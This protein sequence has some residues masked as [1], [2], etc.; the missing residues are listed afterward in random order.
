MLK[1]CANCL[2]SAKP[3]RRER[4]V[5]SKQT[6]SSEFVYAEPLVVYHTSDSDEFGGESDGAEGSIAFHM[7][8]FTMSNTPPPLPERNKH[9][10]SD[11]LTAT[12]D[13]VESRFI[14]EELR[15]EEEERRDI[16][17][18][19]LNV[20][21]EQNKEEQREGS[22]SR[23]KSTR[24]QLYNMS[25][26]SA[27]SPSTPRRAPRRVPSSL[28]QLQALDLFKRSVTPAAS[29]LKRSKRPIS[30]QSEDTLILES[31]NY[32]R[33]IERRRGEILKLMER[34]VL[35]KEIERRLVRVMQQTKKK[36]KKR[37]RKGRS[38]VSTGN[39]FSRIGLTID[40]KSKS[41][42][43]RKKSKIRKSRKKYYRRHH[44][45]CFKC[46]T[47]SFGA[48]F[49]AMG[50][51]LLSSDDDCLLDDGLTDSSPTSASTRTPTPKMLLKD[52]KVRWPVFQYGGKSG[53]GMLISASVD[54]IFAPAAKKKKPQP[55]REN[56]SLVA[57]K[58]AD[59]ATSANNKKSNE[60]TP[61]KKHHI[62]QDERSL[63][64][65]LQVRD[66]RSQRQYIPVVQPE[67]PFRKAP[68]HGNM[69]VLKF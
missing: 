55:G 66:E 46:V 19:E 37:K 51:P 32:V 63:V 3:S 20:A 8:D 33:Q 28:E 62:L 49:R 25:M 58:Y 59:N 21:V 35:T 11:L 9:R 16:V 54:G 10:Q 12:P 38:S 47:S 29:L 17:E 60:A 64:G 52:G 44:R 68:W 69:H 14:A 65:W 61:S 13:L 56:F 30:A 39:P 45:F 41:W 50:K 34:N 23:T 6:Y 4:R 18:E 7:S 26:I 40:R 27:T 48:L 1:S 5:S 24:F 43:T 67:G 53:S 22:K 42:T 31:E 36:V 15:E 2:I 57:E